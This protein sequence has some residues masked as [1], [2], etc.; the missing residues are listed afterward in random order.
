MY[1]KLLILMKWP[2]WGTIELESFEEKGTRSKYQL[3]YIDFELH[4]YRKTDKS[5]Y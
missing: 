1:T 2:K 4:S 5:S 3:T